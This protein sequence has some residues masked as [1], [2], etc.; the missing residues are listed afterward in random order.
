MHYVAI[1]CLIAGVVIVVVSVIGGY[2]QR[3]MGDEVIASTYW[4]GA[5][6]VVLTLLGVFNV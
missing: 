5:F 4:L 3:I 2:F 6:G 1:G